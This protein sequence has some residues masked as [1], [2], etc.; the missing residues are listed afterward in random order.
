M[1]FPRMFGH[2]RVLLWPSPMS[3]ALDPVFFRF[4]GRLGGQ[5]G[6]KQ[7]RDLLFFV[8]GWGVILPKKEEQSWRPYALSFLLGAVGLGFWLG[9]F[10]GCSNFQGSFVGVCIGS[11]EFFPG[12][13]QVVPTFYNLPSC[14]RL[15]SHLMVWI[16]LVLGFK[17]PV[18]VFFSLRLKGVLGSL[19]KMMRGLRKTSCLPFWSL[20]LR[21]P[22]Q[23]L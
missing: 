15:H 16:S 11:S 10:L 18:L 21:L 5:A 20:F 9:I 23:A 3:N 14:K 4:V 6:N 22:Q 8:L 17:P 2:F 19:K 7:W 13:C 12:W 1:V